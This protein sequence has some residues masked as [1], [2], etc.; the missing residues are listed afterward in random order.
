M[1]DS[2]LFE[3][4]A[5]PRCKGGIHE[6]GMFVLCRRCELA[7]PVLD[8]SIPDMIIEEAWPLQKAE[9][10]GFKHDLKIE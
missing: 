10:N 1:I 3:L 2:K 9:K 7:F 4:M 5:C 8:Q 6:K